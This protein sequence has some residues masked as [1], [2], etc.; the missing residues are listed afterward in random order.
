MCTRAPI[1]IGSHVMFGPGVT[2]VTGDHR[3]DI[4]GKYMDEITDADKRPEDDIAVNIEDDVWIGANA[5]ILKGVTLSKG[6]I[7]AAGSLV[8]KSVPP[9]T[10]VGGYQHM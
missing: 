8:N 4:V 10:I 1:H 3:F 6:C 7:V 5:T 9:Y 2:I